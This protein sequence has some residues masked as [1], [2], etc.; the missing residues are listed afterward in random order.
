MLEELKRAQTDDELSQREL[1]R[2]LHI[3]QSYLSRLMARKAHLTAG[4]SRKIRRFL[5]HRKGLQQD[6]TLWAAK[7]AEAAEQSTA[8]REAVEAIFRLMHNDA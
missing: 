7:I 3:S 6:L 2:Q 4:S 8:F 5:E 1:A